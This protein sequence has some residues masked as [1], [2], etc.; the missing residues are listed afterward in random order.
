[1]IMYPARS[2]AAKR[3]CLTQKMYLESTTI[4]NAFSGLKH[5]IHYHNTSKNLPNAIV[6][7]TFQEALFKHKSDDMSKFSLFY[8]KMSLK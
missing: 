1:M 5:G 6:V 2:S 8:C 3:G 7:P 4:P